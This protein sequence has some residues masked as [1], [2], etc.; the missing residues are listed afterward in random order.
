MAKDCPSCRHYLNNAQLAEPICR[1]GVTYGSR[2][3]PSAST[4]TMRSDSWFGAAGCGQDARFWERK[5]RENARGGK[6]AN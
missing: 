4:R 6:S 2:P 5:V 1:H 3:V